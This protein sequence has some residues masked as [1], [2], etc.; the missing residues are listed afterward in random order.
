M[1]AWLDIVVIW[2][3][4]CVAILCVFFFF[5][6]F[7]HAAVL[8]L[9]AGMPIL[10]YFPFFC[11]LARSGKHL[12]VNIFYFLLFHLSL[13]EVCLF[14]CSFSVRRHAHVDFQ[15]FSLKSSGI[16]VFETASLA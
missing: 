4:M 11:F 12:Y 16:P 3:G 7:L 6:N 15:L 1:Q 8:L 10:H 5:F 2:Q 14:L 13:S 9:F